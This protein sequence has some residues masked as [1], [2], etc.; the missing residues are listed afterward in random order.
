[1]PKAKVKK[2]STTV[3]VKKQQSPVKIIVK[4]TNKKKA[5]IQSSRTMSPALRKAIEEDVMQLQEPTEAFLIPRLSSVPRVPHLFPAVYSPQGLGN[6]GGLIMIRPQM[7]D[8]LT[9]FIEGPP[10]SFSMSKIR[11][12]N[13][14]QVPDTPANVWY[15]LYDPI[16]GS[17]P[18]SRASVY[19][20][21][22]N[23]ATFRTIRNNTKQIEDGAQVYRI[24]SEVTTAATVQFRILP[25][26]GTAP[27]G[28]VCGVFD[29]SGT[30]IGQTT[31]S[32]VGPILTINVTMPIG[33]YEGLI[34]AVRNNVAIQD[35]TFSFSVTLPTTGV[36]FTAQN[37]A[38]TYDMAQL[39][40]QPAVAADYK[41]SATS[42]V[43]ALWTLMQNQT[44]ELYKQGRIGHCQIPAQT[45]RFFPTNSEDALKTM[46]SMLSLTQPNL[47]LA[48]GGQRSYLWE[49]AE[50]LFHRN[51]KLLD[52]IAE[53]NILP[54]I[55]FGWRVGKKD[56]LQPRD[57]LQL[58]VNIKLNVEYFTLSPVA[59]PFV[60]PCFMTELYQLVHMA[61]AQA[62]CGEDMGGE[63]PKHLDRMRRI[64]KKVASNPYVQK[65]AIEAGRSFLTTTIKHAPKLLAML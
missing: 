58:T 21:F 32:Y 49:D 14:A 65:A 60:A 23:I 38:F 56:L 3:K 22:V 15:T 20:E 33:T 61:M 47:L 53:T 29:G 18:E 42:C 44:A 50:D 6:E 4:P 16:L 43:T 26:P 10:L 27:Y 45:E 62:E 57:P 54:T 35:Q 41:A 19:P 55:C 63:N 30:L 11:A 37:Y 7:E 8:T 5:Q 28:G 13:Y 1:M 48:T 36:T 12:C 52:A 40:D 31:F 34:F 2:Q 59:P 9:E 17:T 39:M 51:Y 46:S 25:T 24:K 64:A